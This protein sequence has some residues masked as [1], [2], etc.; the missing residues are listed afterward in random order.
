MCVTQERNSA[1]AM[2]NMPQLQ[3]E[4]YAVKAYAVGCG[5]AMRIEMP[6][7]YHIVQLRSSSYQIRCN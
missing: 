3:A 4:K 6:I 7:P 5:M 2:K 1:S